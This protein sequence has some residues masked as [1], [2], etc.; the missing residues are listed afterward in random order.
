MGYE[1][2]IERP[3]TVPAAAPRKR[4]GKVGRLAAIVALA[5][6]AAILV[7]FVGIGSRSLWLD[8]AYSAW[9]SGMSWIG[10][11]AEMPKY[12]THPPVYYSILKLWREL[13][14]DSAGALRGLS[15]AAGVAA[16]PVIALAARELG[17]L[18]KVRRPLLLAA[19]ACLMIALSPR[20]VT[21]GQDA[22]PYALLLLA[23]AGALT[24]WL[25]LSRSFQG[26]DVPEGT[27]ADWTGLGAATVAILWLHGLGIL[28]AAALL[29]ALVLTAAPSASRA[30]WTRLGATVSV[31][32]I[33]YLPCLL[34]M[35]GRT[36]DWSSGWL[37]WD[38]IAFPG[39]L[40][41]LYGLHRL[42]ESATPI[43][44]RVLMAV[45]LF[46]GIRSLWRSG[47][48]GAAGGLALLILF[49]PLAAALISQLG[50]PLF[51]P[52]TLA[53]VLA[54]AYLIAAYAIA[55]LPRQRLV[56]AAAAVALLF[57]VNLA[58]TLAR[59]SLE[60]WDTAA[61]ILEREMKPGDVIW[62]YPN[63]VQLPLERALAKRRPIVAVP[64]RYPALSAPGYRRSGSPAVVTIDA[65]M[66]Q[67]WAKANRPGPGATV[68][69][70][71]M[72]EAISDPDGTVV[73]ELSRGRRPGRKYEWDSLNLQPLYSDRQ[74]SGPFKP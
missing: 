23:Y 7:R 13:F 72:G 30:R 26:R 29:G 5:T 33:L 60:K 54:P 49:P 2:W 62:A 71:W 27:I 66:A 46:I 20:L 44:A 47:E 21:V 4:T 16:V 10:I 6:L 61:S 57:A 68:W 8:E 40:L 58:Q 56:L 31:V 18:G 24:F 70:V 1:A 19:L 39:A 38:P 28:H 73:E 34:M 69:L 15:A 52:R 74:L 3:E 14:G 50:F 42:D 55:Q 45:L 59:P 65:R 25:R 41:D 67:D 35:A 48:R 17:A 37:H 9:F 22:R 11:W 51:L 64:A 36:G 12:E 43:A 53:A 63:D 32:S